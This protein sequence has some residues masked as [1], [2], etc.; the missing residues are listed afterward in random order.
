M[1]WKVVTVWECGLKKDMREG[2]LHALAGQIRC[3]GAAYNSEQAQRRERNAEHRARIKAARER[4][5]SMMAELGLSESKYSKSQIT[6]NV[7]S[8]GN[9][10]LL[11]KW[12]L[13]LRNTTGYRHWRDYCIEVECRFDAV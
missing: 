7:I 11:L 9:N 5:E 10:P 2:T 13:E 4:Y 6:K 3:N 8:Y 12:T 1:G